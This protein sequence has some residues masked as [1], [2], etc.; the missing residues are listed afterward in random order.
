MIRL[1]ALN[2]K[3]AKS[4]IT[5]GNDMSVISSIARALHRAGTAVFGESWA[6][7]YM[8]VAPVQEPGSMTASPGVGINDRRDTSYSPAIPDTR[9]Q[10]AVR[11]SRAIAASGIPYG[12]NNIFQS[13]T[14]GEVFNVNLKP[15]DPKDEKAVK[16][17]NDLLQKWFLRVGL[18]RK[19]WAALCGRKVIDGSIPNYFI[20]DVAGPRC[21]VFEPTMISQYGVNDLRAIR[22]LDIP[23]SEIE[24]TELTT[25]DVRLPVISQGQEFDAKDPNGICVRDVEHPE[26]H[27]LGCG[28]LA[29]LVLLANRDERHQEAALRKAIASGSIFQSVKVTATKGMTNKDAVAEA[30]AMLGTTLQESGS[31]QCYS[32]N[33]DINMQAPSLGVYEHEAGIRGT[34]T[35]MAAVAGV[36]PT[37]LGIGV[38]VNRASAV[39]MG[40]PAERRM[41]MWRAD[42]A[43]HVEAVTWTSLYYMRAFGLLVVPEDAYDIVVI[44]P[45]LA[46][47]DTEQ[48]LN[49]LA[50]TLTV[51]DMMAGNDWLTSDT[52]Q[53]IA[54]ERL[55]HITDVPLDQ[56][57]EGVPKKQDE[58][59][60]VSEAIA[61]AR[62]AIMRAV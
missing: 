4:Q 52:A 44:M 57:A 15:K 58:R 10:D 16:A 24:L 54:L 20:P 30:V 43:A 51:L 33:M 35:R 47:S 3:V 28:V 12:L 56:A 49:A 2:A 6:T 59:E 62:R 50:T 7:E 21:G 11:W 19:M 23:R 53:A 36:A 45:D 48:L 18:D 17:A 40:S 37:W 8:G 25:D 22:W 31:I 46:P 14:V 41:A 32:D 29:P 9:Q 34:E 60:R 5:G 27:P 38:D 1:N 26:I 13:H 42:F 39:E 55:S 61:E